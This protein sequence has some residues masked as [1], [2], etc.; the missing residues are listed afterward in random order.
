MTPAPVNW[1]L[2]VVLVFVLLLPLDM[3]LVSC[4]WGK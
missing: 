3:G 1:P 4:M 2:V